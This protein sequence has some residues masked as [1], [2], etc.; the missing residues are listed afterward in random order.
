MKTLIA[1]VLAASV[2][3]G[4]CT[5]PDP[6]YVDRIVKV[7]EIVMEQCPAPPQVPPLINT[8]LDFLHA[9]SK[10]SEIA[11]AYVKTVEI[12]D[13]KILQYK[14]ALDVLNEDEPE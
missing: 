11:R 2:L 7:P 3:A 8:P 4:C 6:I 9:E 10:D 5:T 13:I 12:Q 14:A 1:L